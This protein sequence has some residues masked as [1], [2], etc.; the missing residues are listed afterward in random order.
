MVNGAEQE[1]AQPEEELDPFS[2]EGAIEMAKK[3]G[4]YKT[5]KQTIGEG[6][7]IIEENIYADHKS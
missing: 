6:G 5:V 2:S 7:V 4:S 3:D 1:T